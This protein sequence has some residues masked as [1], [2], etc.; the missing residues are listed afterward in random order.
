MVDLSVLNVGLEERPSLSNPRIVS[1]TCIVAPGEKVKAPLFIGSFCTVNF[2]NGTTALSRALFG[3]TSLAL[4][5]IN[6]GAKTVY[7]PSF[8]CDWV[9]ITVR[10]FPPS[11]PLVYLVNIDAALVDSGWVSGS[12][13]LTFSNT[14]CL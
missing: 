1:L 7:T 4:G 2:P 12:N 5:R 10:S 9:L 13:S 8:I 14:W 3:L 11:N 6:G